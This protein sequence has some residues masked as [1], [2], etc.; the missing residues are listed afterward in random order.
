MA[1]LS[2]RCLLFLSTLAFV[3]NSP[4]NKLFSNIYPPQ[5]C[6]SCAIKIQYTHLR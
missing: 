2:K 4:Q 3:F 6:C 1:D 5:Q